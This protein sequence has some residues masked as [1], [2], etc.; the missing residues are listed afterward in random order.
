MPRIFP[1][2]IGAARGANFVQ[3]VVADAHPPILWARIELTN[4]ILGREHYRRERKGLENLRGQ[5]RRDLPI[6]I[7]GC[8]GRQRSI[9][10]LPDLS[11]RTG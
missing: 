7:L 3:F 4:A 10:S 2:T 11:G 5:A 8:I 6:A 9:E 1:P